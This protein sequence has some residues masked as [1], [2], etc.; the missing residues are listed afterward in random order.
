M[1]C[2]VGDAELLRYL[3][4]R[5]TAADMKLRHALLA[6]LVAAIWGANFTVAKIALQSF[7]PLLLAAM[8]FAIS[9]LP[10]FLLARPQ[11]SWTRLVAT[12]STLFVGQFGFL[13]VALKTG[14]PAGMASV[15]TQ[16][17]AFFTI[18]FAALW[19]GERPTSRQLTG[20]AI[21]CCGLA[22][23]ASTVGSQGATALGLALTTAAALSWAIGNLCLRGAGKVDMLAMI[24]WLSLIPPAPLFALSIAF[25]GPAAIGHAFASAS[26]SAVGALLYL[27]VVV[28]LLGYGIW[29]R[30]LNLY[31][32]GAVAPFG[33]L[34]PVFGLI[35]AGV[36]LDEH[37]GAE[38]F[39]GAALVLVGLLALC[40]PLP[41]FRH[42]KTPGA[43]LQ[44]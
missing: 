34:V 41:R 35:C 3:R 11:I 14:M 42:E 15:V 30:L 27:S 24:V 8:R 6:V 17:Q 38:R 29:A 2:A 26:W 13:F 40:V 20:A 10:I 12:A 4:R 22:L 33:L 21:A 37:I 44:R 5:P 7:P 28:T 19:L 31:P 36:V 1:N 18:V 23:I 9:C 39:A 32:A 16:S 43:L 25:E